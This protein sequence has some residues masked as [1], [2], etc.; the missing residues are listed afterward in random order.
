MA[1]YV[2]LKGGMAVPVAPV[3]LLLDLERRGFLVERDGGDLV[4]GP[5]SQLTDADRAAL[6]CW[7]AHALALLDY[8]PPEVA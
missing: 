1:G 3:L 4:V 6:R 5:D 7:K 8:V 2:V